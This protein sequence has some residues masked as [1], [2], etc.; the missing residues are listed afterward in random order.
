MK[1][2]NYTK[3]LIKYL[4]SYTYSLNAE[5]IIILAEDKNEK[6]EILERVNENYDKLRKYHVHI[7]ENE[8][9]FNLFSKDPKDISLEELTKLKDKDIELDLIPILYLLFLLV[10]IVVYL[11][12]RVSTGVLRKDVCNTYDAIK[13]NRISGKDIY[14]KIMS[15]IDNLEE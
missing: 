11:N 9:L 6:K 1:L 5:W 13:N 10:Y 15:L 4:P 8:Y 7:V 2:I 3:T 12:K 14:R